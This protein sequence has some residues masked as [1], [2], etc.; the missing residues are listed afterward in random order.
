MA[1]YN[2]MML[3]TKILEER[4]SKYNGHLKVLRGLGFGTY[5]QADGLTQSGGIVG[6]IWKPA[7]RKVNSEKLIVKNCLIL[8][9]GGGTAAKYVRLYWPDAKISGVDIDPDMIALG[10]KYLGLDQINVKI[11]IQDA[12]NFS[13]KFDLIIVDLYNGE[14]FPDKFGSTEFLNK[15]KSSIKKDGVAIFNRT[16]YGD[17]RPGTVKFGN[18][19]KSIFTKVE[20][21]YPEANLMFICRK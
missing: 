1:N 6:V 15:I 10:K 21:F 3:G 20:W 11:K 12:Y 14:D 18:K 8:G 17:K 4:Q 5:I 13:G 2:T 9:L 19:L 7:L 16:Y